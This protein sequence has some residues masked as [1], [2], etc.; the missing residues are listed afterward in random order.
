M[1]YHSKKAIENLIKRVKEVFEKGNP[2]L[3]MRGKDE[4]N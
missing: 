2:Y 4:K 1:E 3:K